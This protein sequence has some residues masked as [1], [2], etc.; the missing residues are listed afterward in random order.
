MPDPILRA[1]T[2]DDACAVAD[3]ICISTNYWYDVQ[4]GFR[5]FPAGPD[6]CR[7]FTDVYE[8]LDPGCCVVAEEPGTG[9]LMGSC[10]YHPRPTH[11][12]LGIMNVHPNFFGRGVASKLLKSVTD[13]ADRQGKP[14]RLV[15]SAMNLDSF[16]LYSRSGFVPQAAFVDM[17]IAVPAQGWTRDLPARKHVRPARVEDVAGIVALEEEIAGIVREKDY[18]FF[19][20]NR[21]GIWHALVHEDESS[22]KVDG[23][24]CSVIHPGSNMI[25]PGVMRNEHA[26]AA[27]IAA[28][29]D[30]NR[31]RS[32]VFLAPLDRPV[33]VRRMYDWGAKNVEI[34][35]AQVRDVGG[36]AGAVRAYGGVVMP[37][38]MPE[39]A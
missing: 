35:F 10:F 38:F 18:R 23:F 6:S 1:A 26:A 37:T 2:P 5:V 14:A 3:L 25:G 39:T 12:S 19:I 36:A 27:L 17:M 8:A 11:V 21:Q 24:L 16:S 32:P 9:R 20:D 33:L 28:Q 31:G 30:H 4:R 15:S 7:L 34:H 22:G 13:Y 29:L